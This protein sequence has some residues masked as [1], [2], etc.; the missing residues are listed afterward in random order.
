L[1]ARY[2]LPDCFSLDQNLPIGFFTFFESCL[3]DNEVLIGSA[4]HWSLSTFPCDTAIYS[5]Q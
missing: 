2:L 5:K 3:V 4:S 1:L